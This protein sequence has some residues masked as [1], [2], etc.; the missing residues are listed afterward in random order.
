[1]FIHLPE[2]QKSRESK[3]EFYIWYSQTTNRHDTNSYIVCL[4]T[5]FSYGTVILNLCN[6]NTC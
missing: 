2:V 6:C 1:M 3:V 4:P 5:E